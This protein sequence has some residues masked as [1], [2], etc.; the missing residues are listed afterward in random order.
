[1]PRNNTLKY[2]VGRIRL[3]LW[4]TGVNLQIWLAILAFSAFIVS[5]V[6]AN[7][8]DK[9]WYML[10]QLTPIGWIVLIVGGLFGLAMVIAAGGIFYITVIQ[11]ILGKCM[12]NNPT[13]MYEPII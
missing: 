10:D 12:K 6:Y 13:D 1:M 5:T 2:R 11:F 4:P 9:W 3:L 8:P 7:L